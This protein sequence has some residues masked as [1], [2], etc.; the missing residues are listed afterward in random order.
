M[1]EFTRKRRNLGTIALCFLAVILSS[2][3][4]LWPDRIGGI[5]PDRE[6]ALIFEK[7]QCGGGYQY[8]YSG[9]DLY[10]SALMGIRK[11]ISL[12]SGTLWKKIDMTPERCLDMVSHIE[13]RALGLGLL[14]YGFVIQD[15]RGSRIGVWYSILTATTPVWMKDDHTAVIHTPPVDTY[16]RYEKDMD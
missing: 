10:P 1:L 5:V 7:K 15:D 11:G 3:A 9:S 13:T 2:C 6:A 8:F 14:P 4:G 12:E 16:M